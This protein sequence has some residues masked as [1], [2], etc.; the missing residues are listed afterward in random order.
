M[1]PSTALRRQEEREK[2]MIRAWDLLAEGKSCSEVAR[3]LKTYTWTI[4]NW[5]KR[6]H[7]LHSR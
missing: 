3:I 6:L 2:L 4:T 5:R 1:N 7:F